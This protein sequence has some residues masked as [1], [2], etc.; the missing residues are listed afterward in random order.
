MKK[1]KTHAS[2]I[3]ISNDDLHDYFELCK[4][5]HSSYLISEDAAREIAKNIYSNQGDYLLKDTL[6][7]INCRKFR[8]RDGHSYYITVNLL[9]LYLQKKGTPNICASYKKF[10]RCAKSRIKWDP[11]KSFSIID[12]MWNHVKRNAD[13]IS[14]IENFIFSSASTSFT[15]AKHKRQ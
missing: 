1:N 4:Y 15:V 8:F 11:D 5:I 10:A 6:K 12:C 7:K 14:F 2:D 3:E 13:F 9:G